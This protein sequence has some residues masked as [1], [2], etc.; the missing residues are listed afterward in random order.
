MLIRETLTDVEGT[1]IMLGDDEEISLEINGGLASV[2]SDEYAEIMQ[3]RC[4]PWM[5]H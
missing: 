4:W 2:C 5:Q 1:T 3:S